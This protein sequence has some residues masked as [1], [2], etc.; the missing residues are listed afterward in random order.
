MSRVRFQIYNFT[1]DTQTR[2]KKIVDHTKSC[3]KQLVAQP[4]HQPCSYEYLFHFMMRYRQYRFYIVLFKI[5]SIKCGI[6]DTHEYRRICTIDYFVVTNKQ[7]NT[8][9]VLFTQAI[10]LLIFC[11][12]IHNR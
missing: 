10:F 3:S 5:V 8:F 4:P 6:I 12:S 2:N 1:H 7:I 9:Y 11:N